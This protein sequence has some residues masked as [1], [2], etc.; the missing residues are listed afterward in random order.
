MVKQCKY[1]KENS[2]QGKC[3]DYFISHSGKHDRVCCRL[4]EWKRKSGTCPY[5]KT[6]QSHAKS[7]KQ[8][9][10]IGQRTL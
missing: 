7:K 9:N 3:K 6:I 8:L 2:E 1:V 10:K 4:S 5:D